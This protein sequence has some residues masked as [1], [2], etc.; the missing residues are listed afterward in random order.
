MA[1]SRMSSAR[2]AELV[3]G[4]STK[5][6]LQSR[7]TT[8]AVPSST[9][10]SRALWSRLDEAGR[11][12]RLR[13]LAE[14]WLDESG[15]RTLAVLLDAK[16]VRTGR[17]V[18]KLLGIM[19]DAPWSSRTMERWELGPLPGSQSS[20]WPQNFEYY[21]LDL[22]YFEQC[23]ERPQLRLSELFHSKFSD[24]VLLAARTDHALNSGF[25]LSEFASTLRR[26]EATRSLAS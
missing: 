16:S 11:V 24:P 19:A 20:F 18:P 21:Q 3:S 4:E 9:T 23:I 5:A 12:T 13:E 14:R 15:R 8:T 26:A 25:D 1:V 17:S 7:V 10:R 6:R 22:H 2:R